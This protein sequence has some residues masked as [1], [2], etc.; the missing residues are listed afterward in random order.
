M[1]AAGSQPL[2]GGTQVWLGEQTYESV[3]QS[4]ECTHSTQLP[5]DKRQR[6][7]EQGSFSE[8]L[9]RPPLAQLLPLHQPPGH[10]ESA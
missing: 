4:S 5:V 2:P 9:G 10:S 6:P 7:L 3:A 8:Q 1:Q